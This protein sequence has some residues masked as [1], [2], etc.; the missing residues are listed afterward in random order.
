MRKKSANSLPEILVVIECCVV[1]RTVKV[2]SGLVSVFVDMCFDVC[3]G[4]VIVRMF[5]SFEEVKVGVSFI[6]P[7][8]WLV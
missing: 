3:K 2:E 8:W 1:D 6:E 5:T 4:K 7:V